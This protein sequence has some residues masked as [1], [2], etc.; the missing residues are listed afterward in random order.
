MLRSR[1]S[2][3]FFPAGVL[4]LSDVQAEED[5]DVAEVDYVQASP[6]RFHPA[7]PGH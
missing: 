5:V 1:L 3:A 4:A 6:S 7:L 2:K